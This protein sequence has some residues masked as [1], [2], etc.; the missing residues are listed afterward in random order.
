MNEAFIFSRRTRHIFNLSAKR[1]VR[2]LLF[3]TQITPRFSILIH[4]LRVFVGLFHVLLFVTC[5]KKVMSDNQDIGK[6]LRQCPGLS[7][8]SKNGR[9]C[10][11]FPIVR[12][13]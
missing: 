9:V 12:T 3:P 11:F 10:S 7:Y 5:Q 1:R 8:D 6:L 2:V 13:I 4:K